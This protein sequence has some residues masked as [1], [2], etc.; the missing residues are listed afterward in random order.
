M[1]TAD[2]KPHKVLVIGLSKTGTSTL[3]VMLERLGYRVC[4]PR[5]DL[6]RRLHAGDPS[7]VDA[8]LAAYDAFEDWPWPLVYQRAH[9]IYGTR[10]KFVLTTRSF[11]SWFKSL[12]DHGR[13]S[14]PFR[15]MHD[16]YGFYRPVGREA[17][18]R[19]IYEQHNTAVRT[20]FASR[21]DQLL[22]LCL[23]R[24][25]GWDELCR[26]LGEAV[27]AMPVPRSN[28]AVELGASHT[29]RLNTI[30]NDAIGILY[31]RYG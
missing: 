29:E 16:A 20:Y 23:E 15:G 26:F 6:L 3:K 12:T 28:T 4:G 27:P 8:T 25:D 17:A 22:E 24:G 11:E 18:F 2:N 14:N 1:H 5:K 30:V 21:P 19:R 13:R 9:R 31:R 7:S 10:V